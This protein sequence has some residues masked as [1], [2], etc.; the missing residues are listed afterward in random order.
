VRV[1]LLG[2]DVD[3]LVVVLG[4]DDDRQVE[5]LRVGGREAGVAVGTPLHRRADAVAIAQE[6]VV[7]HAQ[8]VA[9]VEER[10]AGQR[11]QQGVHQLDPPP[12]VAQQWRQPA[13]DAEVDARLRVGSVDPVHVVALLVGD[14]LQRQLVVV[15]QEESPLG[16]V[17]DGRRL[18]EDVD[19]R[20]AV[21]LPDGHEQARHD[22]EVEGHVALVAVA[23]VGDGVLRPL[24]GLGQQHPVGIALVDVGAQALQRRVRLGQVLATGALALVEVGHGVEAQPVDAQLEP[25]VEHPR[26]GAEDGRIVVVEVGLMAVEA[27]PV[28][29][30]GDGVPGPVGGLE[31]LEDDPRLAVAVGRVAPD[32]EIAL[33][34]AGRGPPGALEPGVLVGGVVEHQLGD[35]P[36]AVPVGRAQEDLE[37]V[38][39]AVAGV[40]VGVVGDVVAVIPQRRGVEGHQPERGDAQRLEILELAGQPAEIADAVAVAVAE[41]AHVHLVDDRVLVPTAGGRPRLRFGR[42]ARRPNKRCGHSALHFLSPG[43]HLSI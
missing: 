7:A 25:E 12:V 22:R 14:H 41:G 29:G 35:D 24:I 3:R 32:V 4:V 21:L 20:E 43:S 40:D 26:D 18:G 16:I 9:V 36:Q 17:R 42:H 28:V 30:A 19:D 11:E 31:V 39:R 34:A 10:R 13:A 15:A 38:Q 1:A 33:G 23:E 8:L 37:V 27:M 5:P 2:L 6:D